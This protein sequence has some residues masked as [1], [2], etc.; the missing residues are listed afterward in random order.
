MA[1]AAAL[2]FFPPVR[3]HVDEVS[4]FSDEMEGSL[5][6]LRL[7][8]DEDACF[9]DEDSAS[10]PLS[11]TSTQASNLMCDEKMEDNDLAPVLV[12][13]D[14]DEPSSDDDVV[15]VTPPPSS[16][17]SSS[18]RSQR[19]KPNETTYPAPIRNGKLEPDHAKNILHAL[20]HLN[21]H[22]IPD[23]QSI[24]TQVSSA[25]IDPSGLWAD[26]ELIG[27]Y[28]I[29][30][31]FPIIGVGSTT[32]AIQ[33]SDTHV[34]KVARYCHSRDR[35]K[36]EAHTYQRN[37]DVLHSRNYPECFADTKARSVMPQHNPYFA[38]YVDIYV[39]EL[40]KPVRVKNDADFSPYPNHAA[41]LHMKEMNQQTQFLQW[42]LTLDD[43]R[44]VC[45][46]YQ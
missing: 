5:P 23:F 38:F 13:D 41:I 43:K 25:K 11:I 33:I 16:S 12:S 39:Q 19:H 35:R 30:R 26:I 6:P 44:L 2:P 4:V 42:G 8:L 24:P 1:A 46:D 27:R 21:F 7:H 40:V 18:Q 10:P 9:S 14:Q 32:V 31:R 28:L 22:V 29:E 20:I 3:L 15:E 45:Y 36:W 17:Q 37:L 34:A